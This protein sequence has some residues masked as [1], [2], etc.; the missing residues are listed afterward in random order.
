MGTL[1]G[2]TVSMKSSTIDTNHFVIGKGC[3]K[4]NLATLAFDYDIIGEA[5]T[6][7]GGHDLV[8]RLYGHSPAGNKIEIGSA[9]ARPI[10]TG[11]KEYFLSIDTGHGR[12]QAK[13]REITGK[14]TLY[15][16]IPSDYL[17]ADF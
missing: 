9:W 8:F 11:P 13:L 15:R 14:P 12:W 5:V 4:G 3:L 2:E 7:S 17:N 10:R 16:V 6:S 1:I